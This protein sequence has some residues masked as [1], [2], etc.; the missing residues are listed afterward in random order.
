M[1][2]THEEGGV[3]ASAA[4]MLAGLRILLVDDAADTLETLGLLLQY[5]G[6]V[7]TSASSGPQALR[8]AATQPFDLVISDVG[9][10]QMDGYQMIAEMRVQ[11]RSASLPAIALTGFGRPHD[12]RRA[13]QAG[14][15]AHLDKPVDFERMH[16]VI[17]VV[18]AGTRS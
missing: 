15:D 7:V 4:P 9:M 14:F 6:A 17:Q 5:D 18:L 8:L 12:V 13:L 2:G 16:E 1:Q 3:V 10:P 11:P